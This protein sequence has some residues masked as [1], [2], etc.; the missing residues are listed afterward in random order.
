MYCA[1]VAGCQVTAPRLALKGAGVE[2]VIMNVSGSVNQSI[3]DQCAQQDYH[4]A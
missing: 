4:P 2:A 3:A 1:E